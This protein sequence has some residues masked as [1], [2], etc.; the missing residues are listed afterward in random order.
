MNIFSVRYA[1]D[2]DMFASG[3]DMINVV[4][5]LRNT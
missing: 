3:K 2:T 4:S 5:N 1:D